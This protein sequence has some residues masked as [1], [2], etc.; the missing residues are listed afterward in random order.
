MRAAEA[1][2]KGKDHDPKYEIRPGDLLLSRSNTV[3]L[4]GATV[5]V[6][7]CRRQL[8]LSDKSMRLIYC[9]LLDRAWLQFTLASVPARY[10]M[11]KMA[12]GTSGSMRNI[13]QDNVSAVVVALPSLDEQE[14]IVEA[15]EDQLSLIDHLEADL[16]T[17]LKSAQ[18]LRQAILRHAFT[19][20]L[21]PQDPNDEPASELLKLDYQVF[22]A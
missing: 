7:Q 11:S 6:D 3:G 1:V 21:V 13:S 4:V 5:L 14:A 10:Q 9:S 18:A 20:K 2:P 16:D 19:G 15:V 12:T 8:L 22:T 17:K